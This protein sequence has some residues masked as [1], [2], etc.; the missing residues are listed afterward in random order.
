MCQLKAEQSQ[1]NNCAASG[2][3]GTSQQAFL[4]DDADSTSWGNERRFIIAR[5]GLLGVQFTSG[6]ACISLGAKL[7]CHLE[8]KWR[9]PANTRVQPIVAAPTY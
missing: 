5:F 7:E 1:V 8:G 4:I 6:S 2:G 3:L 9:W